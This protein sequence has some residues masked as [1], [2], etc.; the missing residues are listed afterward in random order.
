MISRNINCSSMAKGVLRK[1]TTNCNSLWN[2]AL[3]F[4]KKVANCHINRNI[5]CSSTAKSV[6]RKLTINCNSLWNRAL[7]FW[8]K[9]AIGH[10]FQIFTQKFWMLPKL[11]SIFYSIVKLVLDNFLKW[12]RCCTWQSL[13]LW[14]CC[15][16]VVLQKRLSTKGTK[17][18]MA[19][20]ICIKQFAE[21]V[22]CS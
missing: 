3:V 6:L 4:W 20:G 13:C 16:K 9:G 14:I 1:L 19:A 18:G 11:F 7:V 21:R 10:I 8:K 17:W 15:P 5:N 2:R 22:H 12:W